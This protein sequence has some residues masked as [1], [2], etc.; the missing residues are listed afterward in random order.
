VP[1]DSAGA[2]SAGVP[3]LAAVAGLADSGTFVRVSAT[4]VVASVTLGRECVI[5]AAAVAL[6]SPAGV[7]TDTRVFTLG[8]AGEAAAP[9]ATCAGPAPTAAEAEGS[10]PNVTVAEAEAG[11]E[12]G[13]G[14][15]AG[16]GG[17]AGSVWVG[18]DTV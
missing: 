11:T 15:G 1:A 12:G 9:T 10:L 3:A 17:A 6:W 8:P 5:V 14:S 16:V 4:P 7:A 13:R 2:A 18:A